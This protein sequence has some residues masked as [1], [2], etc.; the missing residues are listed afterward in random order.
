MSVREIEILDFLVAEKCDP[1]DTE[2]YGFGL[3]FVPWYGWV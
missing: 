2:I 3:V 1:D